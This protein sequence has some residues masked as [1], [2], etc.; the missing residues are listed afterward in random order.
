MTKSVAILGCGPAGL[1]VAHAASQCGWDFQIFSKKQKSQLHGAQYLH[2]P[3]PYLECGRPRVIRYQLR[4]SAEQYR[5]KVY[6]PDW[7]G[8]VSP[9]DFWEAHYGWDLRLAYSDLWI[10]YEQQIHDVN[11]T[12]WNGHAS[13]WG[14]YDL[15]ISTVPRT[16]WDED[17]T[18]FESTKIF[19]V[20][21]A[22]MPHVEP[23]YRPEPFSVICEGSPKVPWYR[24]SN[25]F[26]YCTIEWPWD[27]YDYGF[28][29]SPHP[30][31]V[32][33]TKPLRYTGDAASDIVHLGRYG[34]W[35]KG[36]LTSDVFFEAIKVLA[37]DSI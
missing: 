35:Q 8:T 10:E 15:V 11:L 29:P 26:G 24:V 1:L 31:A 13:M 28:K 34:A 20:G 2:Q 7:D 36:V 14:A 17:R 30:R 16:I 6:G 21:D 33:V 12:R 32:A 37:N 18:H 27:N 4:G 3:I 23:P 5:L 9:E 22:E 25:I 19:A